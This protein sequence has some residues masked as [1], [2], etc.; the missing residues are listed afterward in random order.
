VLGLAMLS[1][2]AN[3]L[4]FQIWGRLADRF[5]NKSVLAITG[6]LFMLSILLFP[7]STMPGFYV[8]TI[9]ILVLIHA[10]AGMSSAGV[11]LCTGN[12]ALKLA[13]QGK[14]TYYL[15]INAL[16]SG[17]AATIAPILGGIA[18]D[19]FGHRELRVTFTWTSDAVGRIV[20]VSAM[21]LRGLDFLFMFA[22]V[23]GMYAL[24]RLAFVKEMG[25]VEKGVV[26]LEF[27]G[28]VWRSV[29]HVSNVAGIRHL[30]HFPYSRL[31][32]LF[33]EDTLSHDDSEMSASPGL[34]DVSSI[35]EKMGLNKNSG[36]D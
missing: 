14:A 21:N 32:E 9:P 12:I 11:L 35:K 1:Q 17:V 24:H 13:P 7:F 10:L 2:I 15:A 25:E 34:F 6:P 3:V 29:R 33:D 27:Y 31:M 20:D 30:F 22:V 36:E 16:V 26:L 18:A 19:W 28:L 8:L 5:S 23:L 4:F